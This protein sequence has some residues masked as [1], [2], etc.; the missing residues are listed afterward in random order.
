MSDDPMLA[1]WR[2]V[3]RLRAYARRLEDG[4]RQ[5]SAESAR[6]NAPIV[7]H[8]RLID[9]A[10]RDSGVADLMRDDDT[11]QS[12]GWSGEGAE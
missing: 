6:Y 8:T 2:D 5:M 11:S 10:R 7:L 12:P 3:D 9:D 4:L 1:L